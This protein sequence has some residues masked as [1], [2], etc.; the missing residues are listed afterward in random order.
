MKHYS[1][2]SCANIPFLPQ[3]TIGNVFMFLLRI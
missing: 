1:V 2:F 3:K